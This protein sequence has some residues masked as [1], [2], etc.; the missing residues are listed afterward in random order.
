M[1]RMTGQTR[2][3]RADR[4]H[5]ERPGERANRYLPWRGGGTRQL[6]GEEPDPPTEALRL[7]NQMA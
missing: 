5:P 2:Y 6:L 7:G 1:A 3:E 4:R